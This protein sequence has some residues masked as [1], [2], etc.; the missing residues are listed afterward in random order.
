MGASQH[1]SFRIPGVLPMEIP[2][3]G[4]V[5]LPF[6]GVYQEQP[7]IK[8]WHGREVGLQVLFLHAL[9][10]A[11]SHSILHHLIV[12]SAYF[13]SAQPGCSGQTL[14]LSTPFSAARCC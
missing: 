12:N 3:L 5:W 4:P 2:A 9:I 14:R 7:G 11:S 13:W 8:C 6:A 1:H 10:S